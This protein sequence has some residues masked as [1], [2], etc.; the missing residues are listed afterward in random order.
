[1]LK[2]IVMWTVVEEFEGQ[3]KAQ[4]IENMRTQL[5]GLQAEISEINALEV[6]VNC[7]VS[8]AAYDV[9]LVIIFNDQTALDVYLKHPAHVKVADYIGKV[10]KDRVVVDYIV[11]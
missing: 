7:I 5:S 8:D 2:H 9:V 4:I 11:S 6:G 1:M 3:T 10:R